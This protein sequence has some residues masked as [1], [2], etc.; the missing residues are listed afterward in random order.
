LPEGGILAGWASPPAIRLLK[1]V[2]KDAQYRDS[3][4]TAM[5]YVK[6][7]AAAMSDTRPAVGENRK[8]DL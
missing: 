3:P 4:G 8:V 2:P 6:M 5:S 1:V 7:L